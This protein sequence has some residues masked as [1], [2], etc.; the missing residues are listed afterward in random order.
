MPPAIASLKTYGLVAW[1]RTSWREFAG[2]CALFAVHFIVIV[3]MATTERELL[4]KVIF[5]L[6]WGLCNFAWAG[7]L[8][9]P[10]M[11]AALSLTMFGLIILL[12]RLKYEVLWT[13]LNFL[14]FLI[15]DTDTASFLF[16]IFPSLRWIVPAAAVVIAA[17]LVGIWQLDGFRARRRSALVG[18]GIC[19]VGLASLSLAFPLAGWET[20]QSGGHI[21]KFARSGVEQIVELSNHGFLESA[22]VAAEQLKS[23]PESTCQPTHKVPHIILVHDESS[24]D[25]R[26][27]PG[28]KVPAGYGSHFR[29]F[30]GKQR[31]FVVESNGGSSWFAE[32][33]VLTGLSSRSFGRFAYFLTRIAAGHVER[34][35]P[36][37]LVRCG[38]RTYSFYPS[39]GAFMSA[40]GFQ[41]SAGIQHFYDSHAMGVSQVEPDN[42][43]YD[44]AAKL[45]AR[46]HKSGPLFAFVYLAANHFPWYGRWRPDLMPEWRDP[47]NRPEIDEYLR[48][49]AMSARDYSGFVERLKQDFPGEQFLIVR[50]GDHQPDFASLIL[51]PK[52]DDEGMAQR[53]AS[54]DP[55]H[56]TTYYAIDTIN[57]KPA[58]L[59]SAL[60]TLDGA[61][62][63]LAIMD[64]AGVPLDASFV[65]Q[66]KI[67]VRCHGV[68]YGCQGG[69]EA[70]R[71]NR[72]LIDAGLIRGL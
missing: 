59:S 43:Y 33:N 58:D 48:R 67:F 28:I 39:L 17:L 55:R 70:R 25:I 44:A 19:I 16:T 68:F 27:A 31:H 56:F 72:L 46:E 22:A 66:K 12:S 45:I 52:L 42:F 9:R 62:L 8:R 36:A 4:P 38:Y 71:F 65:E 64:A 61:Y 24:Y 69:A 51:E 26:V 34:G 10:A 3:L 11:A 2:F 1:T 32:Y 30:D 7:A 18:A 41:T 49:Q 5:M 15:I 47:G 20:F 53:M 54:Y 57:Y 60:D 35:L 21:S 23:L 29:S 37:A 14:D 40:R 63:P 50:Y 6:T 13:T